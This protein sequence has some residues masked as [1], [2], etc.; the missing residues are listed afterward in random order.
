MWPGHDA[1]DRS[2]PGLLPRAGLVAMVLILISLGMLFFVSIL[3]YML[4]RVGSAKSPPLGAISVPM[5]LW[6][7]T[8]VVMAG[9]F[10]IHL[11]VRDVRRERQAGLRQW[12]LATLV[13][14]LIFVALQLIFLRQLLAIH[15]EQQS[16]GIALYGL[17]FFLVLLH[18]LHVVGGV[19]SLLLV[20]RGA[21][22]G[23]YDHEQYYPVRNAALYWHFLD[24]VW[25]TMFF[26]FIAL[27]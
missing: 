25:L 23:K 27:R 5:G 21:R 13:I 14:A 4:I 24:G 10:T 18:G 9:S 11:A 26:V 1:P 7:S 17:I 12:L 22:L 19:I 8:A 15:I 2:S 16:H 20:Y 3:G 6:L